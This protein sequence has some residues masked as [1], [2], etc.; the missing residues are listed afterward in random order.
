MCS[1]YANAVIYNLFYYTSFSLMYKKVA[2]E[3]EKSFKATFRIKEHYDI[4]KVV[5]LCNQIAE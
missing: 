1:P 2:E 3:A 4:F 5:R